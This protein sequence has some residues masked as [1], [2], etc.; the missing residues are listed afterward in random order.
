MLAHTVPVSFQWADS[1]LQDSRVLSAL[2]QLISGEDL[3][4]GSLA[5]TVVSSA[6]SITVS[7]CKRQTLFSC[8]SGTFFV[9]PFFSSSN[10]LPFA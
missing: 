4:A 2:A 3:Y 9:S 5:C 8:C 10:T 6:L 7:H 1:V